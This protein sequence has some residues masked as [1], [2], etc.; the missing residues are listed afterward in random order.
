MAGYRDKRTVELLWHGIWAYVRHH[1]IDVMFGCASLEGTDPAQ[2]GDQLALLNAQAGERGEWAASAHGPRF[3]RMDLPCGDPKAAL[4]ALP[5]L[6]KGYLRI[7]AVI[8]DGAVIDHQFG[9]TDVLI[10]LPVSRI[11]PRYVAYYGAEGERYAA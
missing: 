11:N 7:G 3:V 1:R 9:T 5:P 10:V 2:I 8:G 4:K 6:L